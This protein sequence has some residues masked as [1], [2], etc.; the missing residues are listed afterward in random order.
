MSFVHVHSL[1]FIAVVTVGGCSG[2]GPYASPPV[3]VVGV[4]ALPPPPATEVCH[5]EA[6]VTPDERAGLDH[7]AVGSFVSAT[8]FFATVCDDSVS[9]ID[10]A[11][12]CERELY[13]QRAQRACLSGAE[14]ALLGGLNDVAVELVGKVKASLE[15]SRAVLSPADR[16]LL[17]VYSAHNDWRPGT[18]Y[19]VDAG[20]MRVLGVQVPRGPASPTTIVSFETT[21]EVTR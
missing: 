10:E 18:T 7:L 12:R 5:V 6:E 21:P 4:S 8:R 2:L 1:T 11:D 20:Q 14:A 9:Q 3:D 17:T 15:A 16:F 19:P 13:Q